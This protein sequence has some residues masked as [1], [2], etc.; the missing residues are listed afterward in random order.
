LILPQSPP[1]NRRRR[2]AVITGHCL[3]DE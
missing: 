3:P 2:A 1:T